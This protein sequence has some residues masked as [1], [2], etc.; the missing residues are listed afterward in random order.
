MVRKAKVGS[1]LTYEEYTALN[2]QFFS[3]FSQLFP[4]TSTALDN[5]KKRNTKSNLGQP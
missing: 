3:Q 4:S 2:T 1:A 5:Q